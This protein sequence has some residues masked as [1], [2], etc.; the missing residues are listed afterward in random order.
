MDIKASSYKQKVTDLSG[1]NKQKV[2]VGKILAVKPVIFLLDEPTKGIDIAAKASIL[3]IIKEELT[4]FAGIVMTSPSLDD[5]IEIC[6]R[7][8]V[9]Y[10]G[11]IIREFGRKEFNETEIYLSMQGV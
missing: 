7:V 9:L 2:V 8:L 11:K 6:D 4:K 5:L 1:G 3:Q 10:K